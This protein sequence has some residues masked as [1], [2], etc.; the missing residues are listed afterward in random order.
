MR[1]RQKQFYIK[2]QGKKIFVQFVY[3]KKIPAPAVIVA[4]GL[5]SYYPGF[6]DMF[7]KSLVQA[8]Y[9]A[10][11]FHFLG[12]GKSDGKFEQKSTAAMLKN[13]QD[14]LDFVAS[15]PEVK[16][17]GIMGR[18]NGGSL[19]IIHGV[20]K[21]IKAYVLLASPLFYST[22]MGRFVTNA[23]KQGKFF[24]HPSF[25]RKHTKGPGRLPLSFASEMKKFDPILWRNSH[26]V[27]RVMLFQSTKDE[28]VWFS[29][30]HFHNWKKNLPNPKK[31]ILLEGGNHSFKG[32]KRK[33]ISLAIPWFKKYLPIKYR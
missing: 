14:V 21:R 6:L 20:D 27:K 26:K 23:K 25:K 9:I 11:K 17:I 8:G 3:P 19:S 1:H 7:A 33:V 31:L 32:M 22:V 30:K 16:G 28:A 5:R 10:V 24:L 13:F 4:H 2:S 15:H 18:S 12:T 29:E